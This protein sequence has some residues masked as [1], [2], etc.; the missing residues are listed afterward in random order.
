MGETIRHS[1]G[2]MMWMV[3]GG[4]RAMGGRHWHRR[5]H[6]GSLDVAD[7]CVC[8]WCGGYGSKNKPDPK[9]CSVGQELL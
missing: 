6:G 3:G 1:G 4:D 9:K 7:Y 8:F 2:H 5:G